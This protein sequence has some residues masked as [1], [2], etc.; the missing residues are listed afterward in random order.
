MFMTRE[1]ELEVVTTA[2]FLEKNLAQL[3][4]DE[5]N[6]LALCP[7]TPEEPKMP[8]Y[9]LIKPDYP[10]IDTSKVIVPK[11]WK[12][13]IWVGVI[14]ILMP[15][16]LIIKV[17]D[18]P[19]IGSLFGIM[20]YGGIGLIVFSCIKKK[21][22][23]KRLTELYIEKVKNSP[24]YTSKCREIDEAYE[25]DCKNLEKGKREKYQNDLREYEV[26]KQE[27]ENSLY[28]QW[29]K[30]ANA[31]DVSLADT[32]KAL[33]EVY[34]TNIIPGKYRNLS[35]LTFLSSFL[36]TSNYDL[37]FAIERYDKEID[38]IIARTNCEYSAALTGLTQQVL[39]EQQY[40]NYLNEQYISIAEQGN[41]TLESI[42][43]WQ[44]ADLAIREYRRIKAHRS[45]RKNR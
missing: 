17:D 28:P 24:E 22:E 35:A 10:E 33:D 18:F 20:F 42:S 5:E 1:K 29:V 3:Q 23:K 2:Y 11:I 38:Q 21:K 41:E 13:L 16:F 43:N 15:L 31:L 44:K 12:T 26:Y 40:T 6:I 7:E 9:V 27:Y 19:I 14:L 32:K 37:R 30:E 25:R 34:Q 45:A 39:R 8:E 4:E 36:G